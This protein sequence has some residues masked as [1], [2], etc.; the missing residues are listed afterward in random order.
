MN[1]RLVGAW[2]SAIDGRVFLMWEDNDCHWTQSFFM[3]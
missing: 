1:K 3:V 2:V